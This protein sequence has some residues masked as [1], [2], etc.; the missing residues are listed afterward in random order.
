M[1]QMDGYVNACILQ[2]ESH[3]PALSMKGW[4]VGD[5]CY[6]LES[7]IAFVFVESSQV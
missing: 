5:K 7:V 3:E 1:G 6:Y 4:D 2:V